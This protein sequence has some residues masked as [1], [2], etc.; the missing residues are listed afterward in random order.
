MSKKPTLKVTADFTKDFNEIIGKLKKDKV[1]VGIPQSDEPR[2][3][4]EINNATLL[5]IAN[6]GSPQNNIPP[7]PIM[8]IGIENAKPAI[9]AAF[10]SAAKGALTDGASAVD[11]GYERA[12]IVASNSIKKVLNSQEGVP[13][14]K[15]AE[16]TID[17]R[18]RRGFKGTKYWL[19]T[20]QLRNAITYVVVKG[21]VK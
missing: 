7:W 2:E 20:G 18:K 12:G 10:A 15:P 13:P 9:A 1:L 3:D 6:F 4:G 8:K 14:N 5:A 19:V 21:G 11:A 16:A 17:A